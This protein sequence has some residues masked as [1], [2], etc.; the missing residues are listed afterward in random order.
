MADTSVKIDDETR[1]RFQALAA[2]RGMSMRAYLRELAITEE[3]QQKLSRATEFFRAAIA[4]PGFA[5]AFD[6][7]FGPAP[8]AATQRTSRAA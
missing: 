3:N 4:Q 5:E 7:D 8:T 6:R 2:S 1:D